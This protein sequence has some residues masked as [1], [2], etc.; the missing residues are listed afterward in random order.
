MEG[1]SGPDS[2]RLAEYKRTHPDTVFS[3]V[4]GILRAWVPDG[5]GGGELSYGRTE[6]ELLGKLD[7]GDG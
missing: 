1:N 2:S 3:H 4:E 7:A 5:S 6:E